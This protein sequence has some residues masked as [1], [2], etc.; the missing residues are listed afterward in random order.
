MYCRT[1][2]SDTRASTDVPPQRNQSIPRRETQLALH[3]IKDTLESVTSQSR[4]GKLFGEIQ[5]CEQHTLDQPYSPHVLI[6][7]AT[8]PKRTMLVG[9]ARK[10]QRCGPLG[11][12]RLLARLFMSGSDIITPVKALVLLA[13]FLLPPAATACADSADEFYIQQ[14]MDRYFPLPGDARSLSTS[15]STDMTCFGAICVFLNPA[16][17]GQTTRYEVAGALSSERLEGKEFVTNR[18]IRKS[19]QA[20]YAL[21]AI[22]LGNDE[23][24][25]SA[26]GTIALA[27]TR[28]Q[29]DVNDEIA[30]RPDGHTR[31]VGYG[32][33][34]NES[35]SL[36][37]TL[38]FYDDQLNTDIADIHSHARLLHLFATQYK[39][40]SDVLFG[41][42]FKLGIGQSDT[43]DY[44]LQS[45]GLS[46][47]R[48]Y[49]GTA[50]VSKTFSALT[51][52]LAVDYSYVDSSGTLETVSDEV[53][54]G[55]AEEGSSASLRIGAEHRFTR[56]IT[57]RG[58]ARWYT[59]SN[60]E[61]HRDNVDDLDGSLSELGVSAGL[62]YTFFE[63]GSY[64]TGAA[65]DYGADF[66]TTA[67][68]QWTHLVSARIPFGDTKD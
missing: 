19:E 68:G 38:T 58:G 28:Y 17:L 49:A 3:D 57:V 35:L 54:F 1:I 12:F 27:Y 13:A 47:P 51:T 48:E 53:V 15:G 32:I 39:A 16:G 42:V 36:G 29:G 52:S 8:F 11:I 41:A 21:G 59:V 20:G 14:A 31:T 40:S 9:G 61:F 63:T 26:Y 6:W 60:Y 66:I 7:S 65:L 10:R 37:Y 46:K 24:G 62:G 64:F 44:A 56:D 23:H 33:A 45:D 34:L 55:G 43:E 22:P 2:D 18:S 50:G 25:G 30:S 5:L 4:T 67:D